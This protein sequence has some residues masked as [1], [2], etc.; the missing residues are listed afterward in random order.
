MLTGEGSAENNSYN[1]GKTLSV[2]K[3][4]KNCIV[5]SSSLFLQV[6]LIFFEKNFK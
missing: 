1:W 3:I 4:Y 6:D 5:N 2:E